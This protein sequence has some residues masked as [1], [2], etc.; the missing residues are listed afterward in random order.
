[1]GS[2][3]RHYAN[4]GPVMVRR[5]VKIFRISTHGFSGPALA[6]TTLDELLTIF[7]YIILDNYILVDLV[8]NWSSRIAVYTLSI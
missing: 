3:G 6:Y 1:M 4:D 8:R 7:F 2:Q 5:P